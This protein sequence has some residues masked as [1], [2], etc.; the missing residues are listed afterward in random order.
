MR[1]LQ[2]FDGQCNRQIHD[3]FSVREF[4][5][6][7]LAHYTRNDIFMRQTLLR[8]SL[9]RGRTFWP[10]ELRTAVARQDAKVPPLFMGRDA[11]GHSLSFP[12]IRFVGA[13]TWVGVLAAPGHEVLLLTHVGAVI[14]AATQTLGT[15]LPVELEEHELLIERSHTPMRYRANNVAFKKRS[16]SART[17]STGELFA[18]RLVQSLERQAAQFGMDCPM[19][20]EIEVA[21]VC[22]ERELPMDLKTD[23][24]VTREKVSLLPRVEFTMF[25]KLSGLW[26]AGNLSSR[27]Y[28]RISTW[29]GH[30]HGQERAA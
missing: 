1:L 2:P 28:G 21:N 24:G 9:P 17:R 23:Q 20:D 11:A 4:A 3:L 8:L 26:F 7:M 10:D 25:A 18:E 12:P 16:N 27:G 14:S 30:D 15:A 13:K 29:L 22:I 6:K 5:D 19:A